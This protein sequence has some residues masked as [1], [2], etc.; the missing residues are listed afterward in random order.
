MSIRFIVTHGG[1]SSSFY[2]IRNDYQ[3][4]F[5]HYNTLFHIYSLGKR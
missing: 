4:Q 3:C 1:V 2:L 5:L